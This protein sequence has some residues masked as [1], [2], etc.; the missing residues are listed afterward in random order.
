MVPEGSLRTNSIMEVPRP[1]I[2]AA[3]PPASSEAALISLS[4]EYPRPTVTV[5]TI[6][7]VSRTTTPRVPRSFATAQARVPA[8][9]RPPGMDV[10][11]TILVSPPGPRAK[12]LAGSLRRYGVPDETQQTTEK[13][14][15]GGSDLGN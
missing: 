7:T 2:A 3:A 10:A 14:P 9:C 8:S 13:C 15:R 1:E 12:A 11:R 4:R 6:E 5:S